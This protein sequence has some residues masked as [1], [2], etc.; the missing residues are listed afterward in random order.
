LTDLYNNNISL[1]TT[2]QV[3]CSVVIVVLVVVVIIIIIIIITIIIDVVVFIVVVIVVLLLYQHNFVSFFLP[4][5]L[6]YPVI[7]RF[8]SVLLHKVPL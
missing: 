4:R 3:R 5:R 8:T 1:I 7:S 2:S 6:Y